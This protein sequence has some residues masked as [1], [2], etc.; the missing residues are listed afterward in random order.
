MR[1]WREYVAEAA[2]LGMFMLSAAAF[3]VLLQHPASPVRQAI[4]DALL[5]RVLM[6]VAMG[7]TAAAI[8][9][10]PLGA[11]SGAHMNPA[12]TLAFLSLG[13]IRARHAAGYI[14]AQFAGGWTGT[15]VA[16]A[17]LGPLFTHPT[18]N[19][20][21]TLPGEG[22]IWPAATGELAIS[23]LTLSI[24]LAVSARPTWMR[25][26]G[27]VAGVVVMLNIVVEDPLSGMSMN[28]ARS[29]GPALV[30]GNLTAIWIYLLVPP[31]AMQLAAALHRL[32]RTPGC[33]KLNHSP[34]VRC[35]FCDA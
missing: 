11:R 3:A 20:V 33:A 25:A 7:A 5:R 29:L 15:I 10:S 12:V 19:F 9:Y 28:P 21:Q 4:D 22:G 17:V 13:R 26:T 2:A 30:A 6:G 35:L 1:H 18:V 8:I 23:F 16:L 32:L 27:L 24:L 34:R 31:V 14:A